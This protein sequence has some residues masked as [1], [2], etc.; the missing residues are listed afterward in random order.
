MNTGI[1]KI[2]NPSNNKIYVGSAINLQK[3]FKQH[4][5]RL[6]KNCHKNIHLQR[7]YNI[8]IIDFIFEVLEYCDKENLIEREQYYI[9]TLNPE[10]NIAPK[11]YSSLGIIRREE[12]KDKIKNSLT[13]KKQ[14]IETIEK[15]RIKL[16]GM[17][18]SDDIKK[19]LSEQQKGQNNSLIK[20]G[21]GF[22]KQIE[23]MKIANTGKTRDKSIGRKIALKLAKPIIQLTLSEE[24]IKE[25]ESA[26]EIERQ[27]GFAN[28]L[29]NRVCSGK[30]HSGQVNKT[31]YGFKWRFK[32]D[33]ENNKK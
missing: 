30:V 14:S 26:N 31:A 10:Y 5:E 18:R 21:K 25:W 17:I 24:F 32:I 27:L 29:I 13:G 33:Y 15:R 19:V 9:D 2:I 20:S 8:K 16:K 3:R 22:D 4:I 12:T 11:A 7:A 23:A 1:Y 28:N 6:D